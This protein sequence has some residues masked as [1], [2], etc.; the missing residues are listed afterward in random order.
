MLG[1]LADNLLTL[2]EAHRF[3]NDGIVL[4]TGLYW[5]SFGIFRELLRGLAICST[6]SHEVP[7]GIAVDT[8]GVDFALLASD[9]AVIEHP[10]HYRDARNQGMC[11]KLSARI[12]REEIFSRTGIQFLDINS[13]CQLYALR[14]AGSPALEIAAKLLFMPDLFSY[15]LTGRICSELTIASTSQF[16]NPREKCW[17]TDLLEQIGVRASLAADVVQ[18]GTMLGPLLPRLAS[19]CGMPARTAVFATASHDTASA[20]AAVPAHGEDWCYISSGTWSLMGVET[21][22][23]V[24]TER[25]RQLNFTNEAGAGGRV[26]LLKNIAGL[27]LLQECRREWALAGREYSYEQ[28]TQMAA[29]AESCGT[30]LDPDQFYEPGGMPRQIARYCERTG[31]KTPAEPGQ[32]CRVILESLARTYARVLGDLEELTGRRLNTIH[33][34]GGGS[35]NELLNQMTTAATG[36]T[37]VAGPVEATAAGNILVQA[38]GAGVL[39]SLEEAREVVRRS[40]PLKT[41]RATA[42]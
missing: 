41:Y 25:A 6:R 8:W 2:E 32:M 29:E 13:L 15:W 27:W 31:Q 9:G 24:I 7:V 37:V 42:V 17:A 3:A 10:R 11:D 36:R 35:R 14:L 5:N 39:P 38:I 28:L 33:I 4:P 21:I 26:R 19:A 23:P 34:V 18:P 30:L 22:E 40:F 20:V 1:T 16:Y 12:P